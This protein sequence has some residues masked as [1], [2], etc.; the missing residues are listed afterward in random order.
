MKKIKYIIS[1]LLFVFLVGFSSIEAGEL[2]LNKKKIYATLKENGNMDVV[3]TWNITVEDT[4]T[5]YKTFKLDG[6]GFDGIFNGKVYEITS[7]GNKIPLEKINIEKYHVIKDSYYSLV[8]SKGEHEIAW[9]VS[10]DAK[11]TKTYEISYQVKNII[12]KYNDY[13]ELYWQFIGN[14]FEIN[15]DKIE[16]VIELPS[17]TY[18]IDQI[19]AWAHGQL[20]GIINIV[21]N[22]KIE[23][24]VENFS[25]NKMLEIRLAIPRDLF[26]GS[27]KEINENNLDAV[28][29]EETGWANEANKK[30]EKAI[31]KSKMITKATETIANG[32][33]IALIIF[34]SLKIIKYYD[35]LKNNKKLKPE[36]KLEYFRDIPGE[37]STPAEGAFMHYFDRGMLDLAMP[38]IISATM[39]NLALKKVIE[40]EI[41]EKSFG[42]KEVNVKIT[43]DDKDLKADEKE[44]YNYI[45]KIVKKENSFTMKDFEKYTSRYTEVF[46]KMVE[47]IKENTKREQIEKNN[48]DQG[49]R[50]T[51]YKWLTKCVISIV[52]SIFIMIASVALISIPAKYPV[53]LGISSILL[54]IT[55]I[56]SG[57]IGNVFVGLTQK[58]VNEKE[59]WRALEKYLKDFSLLNEKEV[60]DLILWE[61]YLVFATMFGIA[62]KVLKQ[63]KIIYP[64]DTNKNAFIG[65]TYMNVMYHGGLNNSLIQAINNSVNISYGNVYSSG[66]GAG[67]GFSGGG[68]GGFGGGGGR[69]SLKTKKV[70]I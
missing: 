60:P 52:I 62:D 15:V 13:A 39:L 33:G 24:E 40:F 66:T 63:I 68:G 67:G 64:Q 58:G 44:V 1:F 49:V 46:T 27:F 61:K 23:F 7:D 38:K 45:T 50:K 28:I 41:I 4:N 2:H 34:T 16:G 25:K 56:I 53:F 65:T 12:H 5:L 47:G 19:K 17:N 14:E 32:L 21:S 42:K 57:L 37:K 29:A 70:S 6:V 20:N 26:P 51:Y 3:E 54:M 22:D 43:G 31:I 69:R 11:E 8:N 30:R 36:I 18:A 35:I 48:F 55:G 10:I 59:E 9:G